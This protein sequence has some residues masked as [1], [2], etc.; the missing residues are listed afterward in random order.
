M[1]AGYELREAPTLYVP[2]RGITGP[3]V[4]TPAECA[5]VLSG[6]WL[7]SLE[8][9]AALP[10]DFLGRFVRAEAIKTEMR[11]CY[12]AAAKRGH[13]RDASDWLARREGLPVERR[14]DFLARSL[15]FWQEY[16]QVNLDLI[17]EDPVYSITQMGVT[18]S[19]TLIWDEY[20]PAA[21]GQGRC[22]ESYFGGEATSSTVERIGVFV[23]TTAGVTPVAYT[24]NKMNS[25]SVAAAGT[26]ATAYTTQ[27][28]YP[29]NPNFVHAFNAFGGT[30]RWVPQPG[31][32]QYVLGAGTVGEPLDWQP[33]AGAAVMSS[34][35][36]VEEL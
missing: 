27:P 19:I 32:E 25:R 16:E 15:A 22:L 30:D 7:P 9:L 1:I 3:V 18:A 6:R 2:T 13:V 20:K 21:A 23:A 29:T 11:R 31:E 4:P 35:H 17:P 8:R 33:K 26:A 14:E 24:P 36:M 12:A 34:H 28:V 5:R 10:P